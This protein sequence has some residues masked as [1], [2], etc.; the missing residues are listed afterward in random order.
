MLMR[1]LA[2]RLAA[3]LA[4]TLT[5]TVAFGQSSVPIGVPLPSTIPSMQLRGPPIGTR[6]VNT[7]TGTTLLFNAAGQPVLG[8][9]GVQQTTTFSFG[10]PAPIAL[11]PN[12]NNITS[13]NNGSIVLPG[14]VFNQLPPSASGGGGISGGIGGGIGGIGGGISGGIG[15]GIGGIGGGISGGIGGGICGGI[16]GIGGGIS[17]GIGGIGGGIGGIGGGGIGGIGGFAFPGAGIGGG[18]QGA[19]SGSSALLGASSTNGVS[20]STAGFGGFGGGFGGVLGA[21]GGRGF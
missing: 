5:A 3:V 19:T 10:V 4:L 20:Q 11:M 2:M 15:G 21:L 18:L 1:L 9:N 8:A 6:P 12:H 17:G 14:L 7:L 16:G 13:L